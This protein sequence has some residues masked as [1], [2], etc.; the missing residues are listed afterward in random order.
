MMKDN[1]PPAAD[2]A[3]WKQFEAIGLTPAKGFDPDNLS[4]ATQKVWSVATKPA[5]RS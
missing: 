5:G 4:P 1:P 3:F 2:S